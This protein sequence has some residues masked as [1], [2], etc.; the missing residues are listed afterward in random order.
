M[1]YYYILLSR[2]QLT[3]CAIAY[4]YSAQMR[5]TSEFFRLR[6]PRP[7]CLHS[8]KCHFRCSFI[9]RTHRI[10]YHADSLT[11]SKQPQRR[12]LHR[13]FGC[14][15]DQNKLIRFQFAEQPVNS[16]LVERV[17]APLVK[18]NLSIRQQHIYRQIRIRICR[19]AC[20]I[21]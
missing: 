16:R 17:R 2:S 12:C 14:C 18:D 21:A 10:N 20:S 4:P 19:K 11:S 1:S 9:V 5:N 13:T 7:H 6:Q 15:P 8:P 3:P